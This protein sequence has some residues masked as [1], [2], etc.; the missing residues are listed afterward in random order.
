M[1]VN[2]CTTTPIAKTA[3]SLGHYDPTIVL[4]AHE[5]N[6]IPYSNTL[7]HPLVFVGSDD[8]LSRRRRHLGPL[9]VHT[10]QSPDHL[11]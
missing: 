11:L 4:M 5:N 10:F 3:S 9:P 7:V 8:N 2:Y 1:H 6:P